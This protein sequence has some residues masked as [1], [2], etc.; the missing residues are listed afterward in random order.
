MESFG[1]KNRVVLPLIFFASLASLSYEITL[2]R[3]FSISLWYHFAFMVISIAMLGIAASGTFL[4]VFPDLKDIRKLPAYALLLAAAIPASYLLANAIPFDPARLSWDRMQLLLISLYY[5]I[6]SVPFF[7]F[8][9][10][11]ST[12]YCAISREANAVYASDLVGAGAGSLAVF[13]LLSLGGPEKSV[14]II[15]SLLATGLL[16]LG[17]RKVRVLALLFLAANMTLLF[18]NPQFIRPRISPY[19]PLAL[20][21][22]FPGAEH[23][24]TYYSPYARVD[25]FKSPAARF[26]P[27]LSFKYLD[28]LPEQTGL[29][30]DASEIYATT[31][32]QDKDRLTFIR[33]LPSSL[34][35][36]LARK[37]DVLII[38]P[39]AGL[40]V[41]TAR[42]FGAKNIYNVDSNPLV[43]QAVSEYGR[44]QGSKIYEENTWTGLG[45][46]WLGQRGE[47]FD[48][49]D[50][51][52]M[53]SFPSASFGFAEDYRFT[54]E[55]FTEYLSH[56]KYDGFLSLNLYIIPPPRTEL[57]LLATLVQ[58]AGDMEVKDIARHIA[59][60]RS[61]DTL[62]VLVKRSALT[63][64]DIRR[65]KDFAREMR[66]DLVYYPGIRPEESNIFIKMQGND[67]AE[68]FKRLL[69]PGARTQFIDDYLFDIR[70]V[71]DERPFFHY[72]LKLKNIRA[73]YRLIGEKWQYFFEEGYLLPLIFV[74]VLIISVV[75]VLLPLA[76]KKSK[77]ENF[78]R[79]AAKLA[80]KRR[81]DTLLPLTYFALLGLAFLFVEVAFIQK[82]ALALENPAYA[83]GAVITSVLI[84]SGLGSLVS[85]RVGA[86]RTPRTI[87]ILAG[88]ILAY[89]AALPAIIVAISRFPLSTRII[90]TVLSVMPAG[91]LMGIPFPLGIT[92]L[93]RTT[94]SLIP[95]AWAVNG[96]FSVLSPVL[97]TMLALTAG[98]NV[99]LMAGAGMYLCAYLIARREQRAESEF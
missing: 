60:I 73:I 54:V 71:S 38:E 53:G 76:R 2:M 57:R 92:T 14:F 61:W 8:G 74:Q 47:Q 28:P 42:Q 26:A 82:M 43:I 56:L 11:V 19:K 36:H 20:A 6:L 25:L 50:L 12:A 58:A 77:E 21:M 10:I 88:I 9:L 5:V 3:V 69:D 62:T 46:T 34:A 84:S 72:Y 66:F 16:S 40:A 13:W 37:D 27:G 44:E 67:Y 85:K 39:R 81:N 55:A 32:E 86:L 22:K 24:G 1:E 83:A 33:Y 48:V 4:S 51:S 96:C 15:S 80:K 95:W 75:L 49:I 89:S 63:A 52:L 99:V 30:V 68:A 29:A 31:D 41:L 98:F 78:L 87:L 7:C 90:V 23:L 64:E 17:D 94:P 93:G 65:I 91:V 79:K 70:P 97:A 45:R 59:V 18:I 35:Y